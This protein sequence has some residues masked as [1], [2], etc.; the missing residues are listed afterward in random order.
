[1]IIFILIYDAHTRDVSDAHTHEDGD[2]DD[3]MIMI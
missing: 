3:V 1:M 2:D